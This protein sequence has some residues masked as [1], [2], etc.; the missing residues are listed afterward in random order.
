M[1]FLADVPAHTGGRGDLFDVIY[2]ETLSVAACD[3]F[4]SQLAQQ[5]AQAKVRAGMG[6]VFLTP[7]SCIQLTSFLL[8]PFVGDGTRMLPHSLVM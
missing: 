5:L 6:C 2:I 3:V 4:N 8:Q 1:T 7:K